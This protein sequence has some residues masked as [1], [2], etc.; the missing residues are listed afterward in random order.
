[1]VG[2]AGVETVVYRAWQNILEQTESGQLVIVWSPERD[3]Q[4][5]DEDRAINPVEGWEEGWKRQEAELGSVKNR[6]GGVKDKRE[7]P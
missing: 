4:D 3:G 2:Y 5:K 7:F 6:E 1:M